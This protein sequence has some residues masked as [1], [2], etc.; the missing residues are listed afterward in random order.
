MDHT[1]LHNIVIYYFEHI[2]YNMSTR[3]TYGCFVN[4]LSNRLSNKYYN[5]ALNNYNLANI[6][7]D[8]DDK[9]A[10]NKLSLKYTYIATLINKYDIDSIIL[11]KNICNNNNNIDNDILNT[12]ITNAKTCYTSLGLCL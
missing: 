12:E 5:L 3:R 6:T 2:I 1:H 8:N 4:Y 11:R 10:Y 7:L 9:L